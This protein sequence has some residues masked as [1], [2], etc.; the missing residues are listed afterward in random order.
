MALVAASGPAGTVGADAARKEPTRTAAV[1]K[2]EGDKQQDGNRKQDGD[3]KKEEPRPACMHCGAT[4]GLVAVCEC[5]PG[6]KKTQQTEYDTTSDPICVP[7]CSGFAW[8]WDR[9]H[10]VGCADRVSGCTAAC[11]A[12][13]GADCCRAWVRQRKKL[14][15]ETKDEDKQVIERKV[16]WVCRG[17]ASGCTGPGP[18]AK[19][20]GWWPAWLRWPHAGL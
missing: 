11:T 20:A 13:C 3:S 1:E 6:T 7:G 19:S 9:R 4:C 15:K 2:K 16:V 10:G 8:P 14:V 12:G 18:A 5:K 17:C